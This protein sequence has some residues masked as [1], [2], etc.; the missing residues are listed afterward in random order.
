[1][2]IPRDRLPLGSSERFPDVPL[3]FCLSSGDGLPEC[4]GADVA[5]QRETIEAEGAGEP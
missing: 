2:R 3:L 5:A 4:G 1:V